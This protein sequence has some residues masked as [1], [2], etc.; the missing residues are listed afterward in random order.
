LSTPTGYPLAS[1]LKLL[2]RLG[3][4]SR[5]LFRDIIGRIKGEPEPYA[6]SWCS[7]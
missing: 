7:T 4:V 1:D 5:D 2:A 3:E 6:L